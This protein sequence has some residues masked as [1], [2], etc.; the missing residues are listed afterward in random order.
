MLFRDKFLVIRPGKVFWDILNRYGFF[1]P[2]YNYTLGFRSETYYNRV[3]LD[4]LI[5]K[6]RIEERE[7]D[8]SNKKRATEEI[9]AYLMEIAEKAMREYACESSSGIGERWY[10]IHCFDLLRRVSFFID[11]RLIRKP[12]LI[13]SFDKR[14]ELIDCVK[15]LV[16]GFFYAGDNMLQ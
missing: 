2:E 1:I 15:D 13:G 6:Y 14:Q 5:C 7:I 4:W 16:S 8:I 9:Y 10:R 11:S 3:D 12:P